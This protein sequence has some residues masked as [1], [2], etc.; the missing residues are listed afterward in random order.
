MA[1]P[2]ALTPAGVKGLVKAVRVPTRLLRQLLS[3]AGGL[4][5]SFELG[6]L[7]NDHASK[8]V[9]SKMAE[10]EGAAGRQIQGI[11]TSEDRQLTAPYSI[12]EIRASGLGWFRACECAR[13]RVGPPFFP[14]GFRSGINFFLL[15][16]LSSFYFLTIC[17]NFHFHLNIPDKILMPLPKLRLFVKFSGLETV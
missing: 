2:T 11:S 4:C 5:R 13:I 14:T 9:G 16:I 15:F 12:S 10:G 3:G 6:P 1:W 8:E 7:G 17:A